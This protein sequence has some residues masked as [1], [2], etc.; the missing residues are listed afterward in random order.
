MRGLPGSG[1]SYLAKKIAQSAE[2]RGKKVGIFSTDDFFTIITKSGKEEYKF[3]I[4]KLQEYHRRNRN[5]VRNAMKENYDIVIVDNTNV[6]V[7]EMQPYAKMAS[8]AGYNIEMLEPQTE[9]RWNI[10]ECVKKCTKNIPY[11]TLVKMEKEYARNIT[12]E[13]VLEAKIP[14]YAL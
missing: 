9:W 5:R 7:W 3:D 10:N 1:K 13:D 12:I 6:R 14:Y 11:I 2:M 4:K 8:K